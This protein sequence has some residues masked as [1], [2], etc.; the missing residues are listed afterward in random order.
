VPDA[1]R[2]EGRQSKLDPASVP[3]EYRGR[4]G[5]T[6]DAQTIPQLRRFLEAG[7]S[8]VAI[9]TSTSLASRLGLPVANALVEPGTTRPLPPDKFYAPG[10]V[11]QV[12]VDTTQPLAWGLPEKLDIFYSNN[13]LFRLQPGSGVR[14]I[15]WFEADNPLRSGWAWGAPYLK[16]AVAVAEAEVGKGR[17]VLLG[18]L[19][20]FRAHPHG[21]FKLLFNGLYVGSAQTVK[22]PPS[23]R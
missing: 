8:I 21:T 10:C 12:R 11:L 22:L 20:A 2:G 5:A 13:P 1:G 6:T 17:L 16:Q 4:I 19:V 18:P 15:A 14:P 7:G 3:A 9:G 23:K